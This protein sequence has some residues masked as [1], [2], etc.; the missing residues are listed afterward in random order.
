MKKRKNKFKSQITRYD[1]KMIV[2]EGFSYKLLKAGGIVD[3][4]MDRRTEEWI[5]N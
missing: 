3:G 2:F 4:K 1:K 5:K